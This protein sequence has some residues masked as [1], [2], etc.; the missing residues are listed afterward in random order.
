MK[1][2]IVPCAI[3]LTLLVAC[4]SDG[5]S[6]A[7][8]SGPT[9]P[10]PQS[11]SMAGR[12]TATLAGGPIANARVEATVA[13]ATTDA[14]GRFTLTASTAPSGNQAVT[15]TAD[16][17]RTRQTTFQW[18]RNR[19]L[20]VD[21]APTA[22]PFDETF[23]NQL[24]RDA[25]DTPTADFP[26]FRWPAALKFYLKTTDENGRPIG[27]DILN[28]VRRGL[29]DGVRYYTAETFEA[30]IEEGI[31]ERAEQVGY[32]NVVAR[33]VIPQGDFCG[34]ASSVG[35]NPMTITLRI[36]RCGCGSIKIPIDIVM[37]EVGHAVGM[38]HVSRRDSIMHATE[39]F[40]CRDVIPSAHE[41]H[42]AALMYAR[43]R[44]NRSPD[45][46]PAEFTL[47]QPNAG[48][49]G[50]PGRPKPAGGTRHTMN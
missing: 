27:A 49:A 21:I 25:L 23:F 41:R 16:G 37:H 36:D 15:I 19:D 32:V 7:P 38:F 28:T 22:P 35:A 12:I 13:S 40:G 42:H 20:V 43:P 2:I 39:D 3:S 34:L 44:G 1:R 9:P 24:A 14:D 11:W 29:R 5:D 26:I 47:L 48:Y 10:A 45:R 18:P 17:H 4:G 46:D 33:Q 31:E 50:A 8:P 30:T 6:P